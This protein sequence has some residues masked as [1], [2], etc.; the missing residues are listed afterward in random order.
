MKVTWGQLTHITCA[1]YF[2]LKWFIKDCNATYLNIS[3]G[4][5]YFNDSSEKAN[6]TELL[7]VEKGNKITRM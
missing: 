2:Y 3:S 6:D 7:P 4:Q 5:P 1:R